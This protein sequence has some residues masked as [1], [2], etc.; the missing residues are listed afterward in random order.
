[1]Q[2]RWRKQ[3]R[4]YWLPRPARS[5]CLV[6]SR[7]PPGSAGRRRHLSTP[8]PPRAFQLPRP[9]DSSARRHRLRVPRNPLQLLGQRG[10]LLH[11]L[12][13]DLEHS[14]GAALCLSQLAVEQGRIIHLWAQQEG[15]ASQRW[16]VWAARFTKPYLE[17]GREAPVA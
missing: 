17:R 6:S 5:T 14:G 4:N 9:V 7:P 1:M 13:E 15:G 16:L 12:G 8:P 3:I 11:Q 10:L 2:L